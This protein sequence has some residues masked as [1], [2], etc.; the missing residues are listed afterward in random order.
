MTGQLRCEL[1]AAGHTRI[2]DASGSRA[3]RARSAA[4]HLFIDEGDNGCGVWGAHVEGRIDAPGPQHRWVDEVR[5]VGGRHDHHLLE[6]RDAVQLGE[7]L[8]NHT[9][10]DRRAAAAASTPLRV[11]AARQRVEL[12]EEH[13][14]GRDGP[15]PR[16][17]L[18]HCLLAVPH[19]AAEELGACGGG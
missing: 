19:V 7:E 12:I 9:R 6:A 8:A 1:S 17:H 3:A 5:A 18:R 10:A 15:G 2:T 11:P 4:T 13:D 16:K 14:A